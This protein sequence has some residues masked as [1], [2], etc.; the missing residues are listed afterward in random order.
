MQ[1]QVPKG[2]ANYE[3]NSLDTAG[4]EAGPRENP[5]LGFRSFA[6]PVREGRK[7]RLRPE[8]F[9]DHYSQAR[10]FWKSMEPAEQSHIVSA[11]VFELSKC[12]LGHIPERM[13]AN[14]RNV[15][16]GL[17]RRVAEAMNLDLPEAS[18]VAAPVQD[19]DPSPALR[20]VGNMK[21]ILR[22]RTVGVL[23][24]DGSSA[25]ALAE[26]ERS[27]DEAGGSVK[28]V[29][30][31]IGGATLSDGS[32]RKADGQLAGTPS[33]LFDA[34]A[35]VL[36]ESA[37]KA[38][39]RESAA[40]QFAADAFGH[41]KAIGRTTG[42]QPLLDRAGVQPDEGVTDLAGFATAATSRYFDRESQV[43]STP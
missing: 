37:A 24:A 28:V 7:S 22:G 15:D 35:L 31:K 34:V 18:P 38:L 27:V 23:I 6:E 40:V 30:E 14:L 43:R 5:H 11:F 13:I 39:C 29:A 25:E 20:V 36:E 17:A 26:I 4:E 33:V 2:R 1:H 8:S 42:A 21:S 19:L 32:R 12:E 10:M 3:P 16:E 41:L 9:S